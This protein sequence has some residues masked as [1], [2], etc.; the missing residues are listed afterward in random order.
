MEADDGGDFLN[1]ALRGK[2]DG[3]CLFHADAVE[4]F[5]KGDTSDLLK[6][7][8]QVVRVVAEDVGYFL[9][10]DGIVMIPDVLQD[11][12]EAVVRDHGAVGDDQGFCMASLHAGQGS[13]QKKM[14]HFGRVFIRFLHGFL[15]EL[16]QEEQG[17]FVPGKVEEEMFLVP[18]MNGKEIIEDA[19]VADLCKEE[20][21][22]V[23]LRE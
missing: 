5:R 6:P 18:C 2:K 14:H 9:E 23:F 19:A 12:S 20:G 21:V 4:L 16:L 7:Q 8:G 13:D 3:S 17:V 11:L 15:E 1:A 22:K 10:G